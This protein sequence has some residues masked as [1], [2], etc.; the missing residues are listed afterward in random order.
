MTSRFRCF[1]DIKID[2]NE[3][4]R[5]VFEL[6]NDTC[7]RTCENFRCLC[8]GEKGRG[9]TL[10]KKLYYK[11]CQFHRVVKDFM[12][13]AGDFTEGNG[14]GGESIYGGT[15]A[16]E[17]FQIKHDR[18]YLLSMANRGPNTNGSQ[19]FITTADASYL[20]GKHVVFG[21]VVAGQSVV[22]EI[23]NLPVDSN[24]SRP[25]KDVVVSHCG[26][27]V[28]ISKNNKQKK[29]K[30][31]TGGE[32]DNH[33]ESGSDSSSSDDQKKKKKSKHKKKEKHRRK[34]EDKR[35]AKLAA[36]AAA[37]EENESDQQLNKTDEKSNE[38][39]GRDMMGLKTTIDPDE[40]PEIP[41]H[42]FLLR[43][44]AN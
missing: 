19:F 37:E 43:P 31:S 15:F 20:D 4:G 10:Y 17:N 14:T 13:Q 2:G 33:A 36:A 29:R 1:F 5:I 34:K 42:K 32:S 11:G 23:E 38:L 6:F 35:L 39:S 44:N 40:I 22:D 7:P 9:L 12:I 26:Q 16:D 27:L 3:A 21:H 30:I 8:T 24:N 28:L 18:P 25:L 41:A